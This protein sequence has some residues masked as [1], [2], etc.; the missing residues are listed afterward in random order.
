MRNIDEI[1]ALTH[2]IIGCA[3]QVHRTLGNGGE[4]YALQLKLST[5]VSQNDYCS[6]TSVSP[7]IAKPILCVVP[8]YSFS[9]FSISVCKIGRYLIRIPQIISSETES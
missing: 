9:N 8:F 5:K 1:N 6:I 4:F 3:M 2:R 7:T